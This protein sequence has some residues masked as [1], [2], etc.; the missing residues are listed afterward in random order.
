M[1]HGPH[2]P[3]APSDGVSL[4]LSHV[5]AQGRQTHGAGEVSQTTTRA[6]KTPPATTTI[7]LRTGDPCYCVSNPGVAE[8]RRQQ[9]LSGKAIYYLLLSD[10]PWAA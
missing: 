5:S 2:K 4:C 10:T 3:I 7:E 9:V 6:D 1:T 8:D